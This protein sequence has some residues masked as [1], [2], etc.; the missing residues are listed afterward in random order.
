MELQKTLHILKL[1]SVRTLILEVLMS[2]EDLLA[3]RLHAS[4]KSEQG[5]HTY[6]PMFL[7]VTAVQKPSRFLSP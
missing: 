6:V 3:R 1:C 5:G 7:L 4:L 2:G